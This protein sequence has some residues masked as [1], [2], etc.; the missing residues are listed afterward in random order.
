MALSIL[1]G[2]VHISIA[3]SPARVAHATHRRAGA[4]S[5]AV[6]MWATLVLSYSRTFRLTVAAR[7]IKFIHSQWRL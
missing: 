3:R 6:G 7:S 4:R 5:A 2:V 1:S